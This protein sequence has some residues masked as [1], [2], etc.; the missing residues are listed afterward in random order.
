[1]KQWH[2]FCL[3]CGAHF[4]RKLMTCPKCKGKQLITLYL[5]I[6]WIE[7]LDKLVE[8]GIKYEQNQN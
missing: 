5:P 4:K 8:R 2:S 1:M 3:G 6:P 7:K